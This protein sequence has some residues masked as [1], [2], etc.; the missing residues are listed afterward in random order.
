MIAPRL[1]RAMFGVL[2]ALWLG[3]P[4]LAQNASS[5]DIQARKSEAEKLKTAAEAS[6][7]EKCTDRCLKAARSLAELSNDYFT[8]GNVQDA[9]AA[10]KEAG[11][12]ALKA[13]QSSLTARKR[14]KQTEIGLR[15]L[16]K[17]IS[18]IEETLNFE[19]RPAVHDI[20]KQIDKA[21][22]AILMSMFETKKELGPDPE[23]K[24]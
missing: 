10:M 20:V 4:A 11:R 3:S 9:H 7:P 13:G 6:D 19:D 12:F 15:K 22:S 18:D 1:L 5:A 21:R 2:L 23:E 17:R 14:R 24:Q 8:S 16:Q